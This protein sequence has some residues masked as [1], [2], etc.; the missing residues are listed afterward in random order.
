MVGLNIPVVHNEERAVRHAN[1]AEVESA[2][3][4]ADAD[5]EATVIGTNQVYGRILLATQ[6]QWV[7]LTSVSGLVMDPTYGWV[8]P[9]ISQVFS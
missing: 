3:I 5:T 2:A 9:T 7:A 6:L 1:N 4:V 8:R